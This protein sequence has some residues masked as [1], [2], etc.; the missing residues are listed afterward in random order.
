MAYKNLYAITVPKAQNVAPF[1]LRLPKDL[2]KIL[3]ALAERER[4]SLND[5]IIYALERWLESKPGR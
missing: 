5:Q 4:R 3:E 1:A 2:K